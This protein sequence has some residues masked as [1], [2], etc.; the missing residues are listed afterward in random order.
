M[1]RFGE[2][3]ARQA[4]E[5][6]EAAATPV[7]APCFHCLKPIEAHDLGVLMPF[8]GGTPEHPTETEV[9]MHR[10]CLL[11][12]CGIGD[13]GALSQSRTGGARVS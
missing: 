3:W 9:A 4:F 12:S 13:S 2:G 7:G 11:E 5:A 8:S 10:A 1:K 6:L